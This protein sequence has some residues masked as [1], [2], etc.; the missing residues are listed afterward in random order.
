VLYK[1][2]KK[3]FFSVL[4]SDFIAYNTQILNAF[5]KYKFIVNKLN[6]NGETPLDLLCKQYNDPKNSEEFMGFDDRQSLLSLIEDLQGN[7]GAKLNTCKVI[8]R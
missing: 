2:C 4:P 1:L 8:N 5:E 3:D 6:K 7:Y